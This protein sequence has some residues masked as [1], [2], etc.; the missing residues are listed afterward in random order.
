MTTFLVSHNLQIQNMNC[1]PWPG[2]QLAAGLERLC[3]SVTAAEVLAHPH[4]RIRLISSSTPSSLA[5]ELVEAWALLR[6]E[7][8]HVVDHA[9]L[10]LGGRKDTPAAVGSPLHP[11]DWGVDL[12]ET[13]DVASF[14]TSIQWEA[15]KSARPADGIF[16][17][18]CQKPTTP[19][20]T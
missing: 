10:A 11:G 17:V 4:W 18:V 5:Q 20:P 7:N 1:P 15:L 8:G 6:S 2:E 19:E 13:P 3:A 9:I 14:L 12:V 16:E